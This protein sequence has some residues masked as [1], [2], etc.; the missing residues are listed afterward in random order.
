M[1]S[2]REHTDYILIVFSFA[3]A[4]VRERGRGSVAAAAA[5]ADGRPAPA[6]ERERS[7]QHAT[8]VSGCAAHTQ[9]PVST[10]QPHSGAPS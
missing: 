4:A 10:Q 9:S 8:D 3:E 6:A 1:C 2:A 5:R 7:Y